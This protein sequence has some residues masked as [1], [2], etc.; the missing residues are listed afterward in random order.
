[1]PAVELQAE[2]MALLLT[3]GLAAAAVAQGVSTLSDA[4]L[5]GRTKA[6]Q[7]LIAAGSHVELAVVQA[8]LPAGADIAAA[9]A[10]GGTA[11]T[12]ATASGKAR[13]LEALR[14]RGAVVGNRE[15]MLATSECHTDV[16]RVLVTSGL[17]ARGSG[18]GDAPILVAAS[19]NCVET[20]KLLL[21]K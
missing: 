9:A 3:I 2:M 16:V 17:N 8:F 19:R 14:T 20:V 4:V 1:M 12:Y 11:A 21:D 13:A 6:V 10:A 7:D 18:D 15:L 5:Y